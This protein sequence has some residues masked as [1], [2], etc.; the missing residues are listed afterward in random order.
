MREITIAEI[1]SKTRGRSAPGA[2]GIRYP[3][4]KQCPNIVF[5]YLEY[6]YNICL[7]TQSR[8]QVAAVSSTAVQSQKA[9][10]AYFASKQILSLQNR[11]GLQDDNSQAEC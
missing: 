1:K 11:V 5:E 3:V 8:C 9:V 6:I 2:D 10:S 7:T 4:L